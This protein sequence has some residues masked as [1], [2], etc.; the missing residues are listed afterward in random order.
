MEETIKLLLHDIY[1]FVE[2]SVKVI[3]K[4]D[5]NKTPDEIYYI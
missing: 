3:I 1:P 4:E 5:I 2:N